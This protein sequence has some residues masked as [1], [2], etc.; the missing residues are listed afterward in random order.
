MRR[1][2]IRTPL[3][4]AGGWYAFALVSDALSVAG[5]AGDGPWCRVG[6]VAAVDVGDAVAELPC[7]AVSDGLPAAAA[8]AD[9]AEPG[10]F[11][12]PGAA[13]GSVCCAVLGVSHRAHPRT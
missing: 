12:F 13:S 8:A 9:G 6:S 3:P 11:D 4:V 1:L 10:E 5:V 2:A 7:V